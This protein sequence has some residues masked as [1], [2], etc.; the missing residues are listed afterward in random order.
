MAD[1][2][3]IFLGIGLLASTLFAFGLVMMKSRG[4]ELAPAQGRGIWRAVRGWFKDPVWLG[5]LGVQIL[6]YILYI[7]ALTGSPVS[8]LAVMMQGGIAI[9]VLITVVFLHENASGREWLGIVGVV[10][11]M[12][13][14]SLTLGNGVESTH[15]DSAALATT[16]IG[17][18]AVAL[19]PYASPRMRDG[20]LAA[21]LA[22]GMAFGLAGLYAKAVTDLFSGNEVFPVW[23]TL[24]TSPWLY[25]TIIANLS[26]M[27][28]LQNSFH[29]ARGIIAM[30]LSSACSNLV[31]IVGGI[32]AFG[33]HLPSATGPAA[34]RI[35]AFSLTILSGGLLA[36]GRE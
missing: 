12:T 10:S 13:L 28:L 32:L 21:A 8:M 23:R 26:G 5:G 34:M 15:A 11:A 33:E 2:T 1:R 29:W 35:T 4:K 18:L 17:A 30:P 22:S 3:R 16:S 25:L 14:V 31:P 9:F 24:I 7:V 27:I 19:L 20:G 36:T 6:G